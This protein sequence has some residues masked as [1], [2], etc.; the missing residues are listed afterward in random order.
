MN[1]IDNFIELQKL[2][3][4]KKLEFV[5]ETGKVD[6]NIEIPP[7]L[8]FPFVENAF[9]HGELHNQQNPILIQ[10]DQDDKYVYFT[11]SNKIASIEKDEV[12]GI[13]L[14]NIKKRL[15][16]I[17]GNKHSFSIIEKDDLFQVSL[18]IPVK[19]D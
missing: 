11:S 17:Y 14:E 10:L 1:Q 5:Q 3:L 19:Y 12:G 13:G 8:F 9:K 4:Q 2:R 18:K 7:L 6:Q 16:L 15:N